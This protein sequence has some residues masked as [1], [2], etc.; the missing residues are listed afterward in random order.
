MIIY[1]ADDG[2]ALIRSS[3]KLDVVEVP[4]EHLL[5]NKIRKYYKFQSID[6][7]CDMY[8]PCFGMIIFSLSMSNK[9]RCQQDPF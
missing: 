3:F 7:P 9:V 1:V 4:L 6:C 8:N 5:N 2:K